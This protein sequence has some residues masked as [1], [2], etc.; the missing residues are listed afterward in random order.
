[1]LALAAT[2]RLV[3]TGAGRIAATAE[4]R[5]R[6]VRDCVVTLEPFE[7]AIEEAFSVVFVPEPLLGAAIDLDGPDEISYAAGAIDL[8]EAVAEQVALAL[9]PYPKSPGAAL[10]DVPADAPAEA[11]E[12]PFAGLARRRH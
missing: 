1:V 2:F 4:L 9:D 11:P 8:G 12:S 7:T 10:P 3:R 5:G 6:L